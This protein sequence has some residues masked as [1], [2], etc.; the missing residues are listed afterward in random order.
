VSALPIVA[1]G[2]ALS[3]RKQQICQPALAMGLLQCLVGCLD[4]A[5]IAMPQ[6]DH[7][8][9]ALEERLKKLKSAHSKRLKNHVLSC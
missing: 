7:K 5:V 1:L 2:P 3:E 8:I 6:L 4:A 9:T